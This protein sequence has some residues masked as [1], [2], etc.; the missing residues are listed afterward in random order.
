VSDVRARWLAEFAVS[1]E[2]AARLDALVER[3]LRWQPA[4]NLVAPSTLPDLWTRHIADSLQL[5]PL[6]PAQA[7]SWVDLGSGAGFPG[8]VIAALAADRR[9][10]LTVSLVES[11]ARKCAFLAEAARA[12]DV[13]VDIQHRRIEAEAPRRHAVLT[14]R[15]L[16]PLDRL[17]GFAITHLAEGGLALFPKGAGV[18][19]ELTAAARS[20]QYQVSRTPSRTDPGGTVLTVT[21]LR[22]ADIHA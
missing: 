9:P 13:L 8:L 18:D 1:R 16:A 7:G 19:A 3:L 4:I 12:M 10:A 5:W 20:W 21:E 17:C 22:R 15:A 11:D 2:T 14:A 6:A